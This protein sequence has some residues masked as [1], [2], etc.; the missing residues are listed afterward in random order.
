P[1]GFLPQFDSPALDSVTDCTNVDG[2]I[3][4]SKD[5]R[6]KDRPFLNGK[7]DAGAFEY[8]PPVA[9]AG[10]D[11]FVHKDNDVFLDGQSS[12]PGE[13]GSIFSWQWDQPGGLPIVMLTDETPYRASFKA[14]EVDRD[15]ILTFK[16]IVTTNKS[17]TAEDTV[18]VTVFHTPKPPVANAGP[19]RTVA[20][21]AAVTLDGRASSDP[22]GEALTY[23]WTQTGGTSVGPLTD[24]ARPSFTAP[25]QPEIL[26][27]TLTVRDPGGLTSSDTVTITVTESASGG[28]DSNDGGGGGGCSLAPSAGLG[29]GNFGLDWLLLLAAMLLVQLRGSRR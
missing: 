2:T 22:N 28:G 7:C 19:D 8:Q 4:I 14:P 1:E 26:T 18:A 12:T 17:Y 16:L 9:H 29:L 15:T 20:P 21:G 5:A 24:T 27:F 6:G 3:I 10:A 13:D 25:D 11:R 23:S